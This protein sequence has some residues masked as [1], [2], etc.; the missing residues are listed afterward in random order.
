MN[1]TKEEIYKE[2][3]NNLGK[4]PQFFKTIPERVLA[5][6]W[7]LFQKTQMED[8]PISQKN[9]QLIGLGISAV[10]GCQYCTYFHTEFARFFGATNEEIEDAVHFAKDTAG[11]SS[12]VN[13]MQTD[14]EQFKADVKDVIKHVKEHQE[15]AV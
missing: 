4:V 7:E 12:Y 11:W 13:G 5:L 15:M 9:R 10:K 6:E 2:M 3:E 1:R 8:S 14:F